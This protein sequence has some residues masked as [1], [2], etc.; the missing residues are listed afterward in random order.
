MLP[1]T[2]THDVIRRRPDDVRHRYIVPFI[3]GSSVCEFFSSWPTRGMKKIK[4]LNK[5]KLK[6]RSSQP[7][8]AMEE[9]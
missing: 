4:I 8:M 5:I 3:M 6:Y 7:T 9:P 2:D 1:R